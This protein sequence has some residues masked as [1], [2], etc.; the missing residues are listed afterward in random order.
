MT[1]TEL[2]STNMNTSSRIMTM[3]KNSAL[4]ST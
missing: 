3:S 4:I 1:A 2:K